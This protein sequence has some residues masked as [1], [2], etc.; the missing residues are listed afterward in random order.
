VVEQVPARLVAVAAFRDMDPPE[1]Q[2]ELV[3]VVIWVAMARLEK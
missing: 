1:A 3:T 2:V